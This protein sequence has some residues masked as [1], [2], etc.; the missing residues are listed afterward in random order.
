[1]LPLDSVRNDPELLGVGKTSTTH[2][3]IRSARSEVEYPE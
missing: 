3:E 1:M 2:L